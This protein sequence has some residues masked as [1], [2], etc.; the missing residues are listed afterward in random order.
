MKK[1]FSFLLSLGLPFMVNA[2]ECEI[3]QPYTGNTG[4]NMTIMLTPAVISSLTVTN[5]DAYIVALTPA[6]TVVGSEVVGG[7]SQTALAVW[8]NDTQTEEVD[9]AD[10][11]ESISF[12][13]VD[14][15]NL[16]DIEMSSPVS[17]STNGTSIQMAPP[18]ITECAAQSSDLPDGWDATLPTTDNTGTI[19]FPAGTLTDLAGDY[20]IAVAGGVRVSE[21]SLVETNGSGGV[22]VIGT[23]S[24]CSCDLANGGEKLT[25]EVYTDGE[26]VPF[27]A[28]ESVPYSANMFKQI[29]EITYE[30][31]TPISYQLSAGWNMVG[32]V[33]TADNNGIVDQMNAALGASD[34]QSTFQV[35]KNVKGKFWSS[36]FA[37]I[38]EFVPGEGYMMYVIG[39]P[40]TVNFQSEGYISGI[41]YDLSS[42]WNMVA[43]T[44][45]VDAESDIVTSVTSALPSGTAQEKFQVIKNV[46]GKF[47]SA[48]FAQINNFIP[49]EAY[50]MYVLGDPTTLNFQRE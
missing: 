23:D 13:L 33:G 18:T 21:P 26:V 39:T 17:Y 22:A 8:G 27:A 34:I 37:Q 9:G 20:I 44:G 7:V 10:N 35:I 2:N 5:S 1:I 28:T 14:G 45:D 30:L 6:G 24:N 31:G 4:S 12:K 40:T 43:F 32:Y 41:E 48:S 46:K 16:Y 19:V 38:N 11:G 42:G 47:W 25:F 3:P 29:F 49:G 15:V 50:M 36:S